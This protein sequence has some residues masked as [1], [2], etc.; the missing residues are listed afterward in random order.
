MSMKA[1]TRGLRESEATDCNHHDVYGEAR[2]AATND[3]E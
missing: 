1:T 3:S 2:Q